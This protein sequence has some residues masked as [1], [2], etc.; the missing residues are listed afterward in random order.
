V[1]NAGYQGS[2]SGPSTFGAGGVNRTTSAAGDLVGVAEDVQYLFVPLGYVSGTSL[3]D[4]ATWNNAL[5][6]SLGLTPG[7]YIYS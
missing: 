7:I 4:T 1:D 2:I 5:F 6:A 3:S